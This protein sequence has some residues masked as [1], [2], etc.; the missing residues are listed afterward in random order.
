MRLKAF[1][2]LGCVLLGLAGPVLAQNQPNIIVIMAD[3]LGWGDI[4]YNGSEIR[5]PV[6]DQLAAQGVMLTRYYTHPTCSPT[7]SSFYT[8]KPALTLGTL[9]PLAPWEDFGVPPDEKLLPAYL[10]DAG[11]T[12]WM[13]GKW[14]LGHAYRDQHPLSRGY[15][16]FYG[17]QGPEINHYTHALNGVPD[18]ERNGEPLDEPGYATYLLRDEAVRLIHE[19]DGGQPFFMHLSFNAPHAPLQAPITAVAAYAEI[20]NYNRRRLA[21]MI[22]ELDS[23][24]G[25]VL[26]AVQ[27]SAA[28]DNTLVVFISDNGGDLPAGASSGPLRGGKMTLYDGG[29]RVPALAWWPGR[30]AAGQR[31]TEFISVHDWL[32]TLAAV[33]GADLNADSE[34]SGVNVWSAIAGDDDV[35]RDNPIVIASAM[36]G[37]PRIVALDQGWKMIRSLTPVPDAPFGFSV[38]LYNLEE[39]PYETNDRAAVEPARVRRLLDFTSGIPA[40]PRQGGTP[41]PPGYDGASGPEIEPNNR[42]PIYPP[43]AG[44]FRNPRPAE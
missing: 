39:D 36:M 32:P 30:L 10:R 11:Y 40:G 16:H 21:A 20:E 6:L 8:G 13:L 19:H 27:S 23:A 42:E 18:W 9:V 28:V 34:R 44:S 33:A 38:E 37:G 35:E 29:V 31:T 43:Q 2:L 3:D 4:G 5:T 41:P 24:V 12:T 17:P 25:A 7:R 15:D 22:T 1:R 26:E 14:H